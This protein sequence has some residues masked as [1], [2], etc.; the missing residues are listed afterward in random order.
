MSLALKDFLLRN[1][2]HKEDMPTSVTRL[3]VMSWLLMCLEQ[4]R[5]LKGPGYAYS[6]RAALAL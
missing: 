1:C 4:R 3:E 2:E 5:D 6:S